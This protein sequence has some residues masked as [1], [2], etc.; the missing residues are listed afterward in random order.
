MRKRLE[1]TFGFIF[2]IFFL[3]LIYIVFDFF[4]SALKEVDPKTSVTILGTMITIGAS[5][6]GIIYNQKQIKQREIQEAHRNKKIEIYNKFITISTNMI[7][8]SNSKIPS[9]QPYEEEVLIEEIFY[10]KKDLLL[11]GSQ[12]V[13]K[14]VLDYENAA[15]NEPKN[16]L[17]AVNNLYKAMREDIGFDNS[18]LKN[19]ELI[20]IFLS[21]AHELDK[22]M[23]KQ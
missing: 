6:F 17:N 22:I 13:I 19:N 10:F 1:L 8:G 9:I 11:W 15:I 14:S 23:K 7:A 2:F 5:V 4:I 16:V 12:K 3:Y 18:K 20:K 21:D